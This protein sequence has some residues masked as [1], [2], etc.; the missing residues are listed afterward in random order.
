A[1]KSTDP[2]KVAMALEGMEYTRLDGTKVKMR[3]SDHQIQMPLNISV[4][5]NEDITWDYDNSGY[6]THVESTIP[7]DKV[8]LPTSCKM[9]RPS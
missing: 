1:A 3:A 4:H 5:T 8:E 2:Q 6:G 7:A 9:E